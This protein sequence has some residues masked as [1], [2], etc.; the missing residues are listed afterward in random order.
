VSASVGGGAGK[1]QG[2]GVGGEGEGNGEGEG[3][4]TS[5]LRE[6]IQGAEGICSPM[7]G[8]TI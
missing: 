4:H 1:G 5:F 3:A 8:T 7:G 2:R 6:R